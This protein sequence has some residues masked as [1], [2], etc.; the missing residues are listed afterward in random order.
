MKIYNAINNYYE[1]K[2]IQDILEEKGLRLATSDV[3]TYI[4]TGSN[5]IILQF[6][7]LEELKAFI[8]GLTFGYNSRILEEAK[9][10]NNV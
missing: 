4:T 6:T 10:S 1:I 7:Q 2:K 9:K 3:E 8:E 5:D